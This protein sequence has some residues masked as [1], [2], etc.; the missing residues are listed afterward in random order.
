MSDIINRMP[1]KIIIKSEIPPKPIKKFNKDD[2]LSISNNSLTQSNVKNDD[3]AY[4]KNL[5]FQRY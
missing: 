1:E 4:P 5:N 3:T 2:E